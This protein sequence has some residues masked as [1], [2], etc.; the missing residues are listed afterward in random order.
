MAHY[1]AALEYFV[2]QTLGLQEN[3]SSVISF[4]HLLEAETCF[5]ILLLITCQCP[6]VFS[7]SL[8]I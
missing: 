8:K 6:S 5:P 7:E 2:T 4:K 3:S 1:C